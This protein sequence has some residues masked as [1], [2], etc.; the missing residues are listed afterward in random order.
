M[1]LRGPGLRRSCIP[2]NAGAVKRHGRA[3]GTSRQGRS[4]CL[5]SRT[6][7]IEH[8]A[9]EK[10]KTRGGG[11]APPGP[12]QV[13]KLRF[14]VKGQA[15]WRGTHSV[16][17]G[18]YSQECG[19]HE[20]LCPFPAAAKGGI[21][22]R[23]G[24]AADGAAGRFRQSGGAGWANPC[25]RQRRRPFAPPSGQLPVRRPAPRRVPQFVAQSALW[26][27]PPVPLSGL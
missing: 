5:H 17:N 1:S 8:S 10:G 3:R 21:R 24:T 9:F 23:K 27:V 6:G 22:S 14:F 19:T 25:A 16:S 13:G 4:P 11:T 20:S 26:P 12:N 2:G 18:K 15:V 7:G